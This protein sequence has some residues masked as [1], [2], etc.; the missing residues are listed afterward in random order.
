MPDSAQVTSFL[1]RRK[2]T[3]PWTH[4]HAARRPKQCSFCLPA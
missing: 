3:T 4:V 2:A 1:L